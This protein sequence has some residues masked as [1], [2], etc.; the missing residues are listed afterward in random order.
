MGLFEILR[1]NLINV[2]KTICKESIIGLLSLFRTEQAYRAEF[3]N[4]ST[5]E[6]LRCG[7]R[8]HFPEWDAQTL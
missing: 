3:T 7:R 6:K 5:L 8:K 4:E 2:E 1:S